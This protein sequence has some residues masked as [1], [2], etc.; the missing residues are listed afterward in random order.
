MTIDRVCDDAK[1]QSFLG[2]VIVIDDDGDR[3]R[4]L[5][6]HL[7][8]DRLRFEANLVIII[9]IIMNYCVSKSFI[10]VAVLIVDYLLEQNKIKK[11]GPDSGL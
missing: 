7:M 1:P 9:I 2:N 11:L 3:V 10:P 5:R 6:I 4:F 8:C